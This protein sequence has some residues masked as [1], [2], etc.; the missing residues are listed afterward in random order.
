VIKN[1]QEQKI[2]SKINGFRLAKMRHRHKGLAQVN[3]KQLLPNREATGFKEVH[4]GETTSSGFSN[5]PNLGS[6]YQFTK[7]AWCDFNSHKQLVCWLLLFT[8]H[9]SGEFTYSLTALTIFS[10]DPGKLDGNNI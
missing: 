5:H 4:C 6:L 2:K 10:T 1:E 9:F 3:R 7:L 8:S